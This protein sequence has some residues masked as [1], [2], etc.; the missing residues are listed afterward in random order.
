MKQLHILGLLLAF[1]SC[2]IDSNELRNDSSETA[3]D[4]HKAYTDSVLGKDK[5][6]FQKRE[7]GLQFLPDSILKYERTDGVLT[8]VM[9]KKAE[10]TSMYGEYNDGY[11][12]IIKVRIMDYCAVPDMIDTDFAI[13]YDAHKSAVQFIELDAPAHHGFYAFTNRQE[14]YLL[15][16]VDERFLVEIEDR[17]AESTT[18]ILDFYANIPLEKLASFGH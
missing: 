10:N 6:C 2:G 12:H 11:N 7:D 16:E 3:I 1:S 14:A 17:G 9:G 5:Y 8:W 15:I 18:D 4:L 13:K